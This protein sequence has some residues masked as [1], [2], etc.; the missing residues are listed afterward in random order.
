M[1]FGGQGERWKERERVLKD[2][3]FCDQSSVAVFVLYISVRV[4]VCMCIYIYSVPLSQVIFQTILWNRCHFTDGETEAQRSSV[5][6]RES[7]CG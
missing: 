7:R 3:V 6:C 1:S 2:K 5:T 4:H